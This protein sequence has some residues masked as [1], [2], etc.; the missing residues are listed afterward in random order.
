MEQGHGDDSRR[1]RRSGA[2]DGPSYALCVFNASNSLVFKSTAPAERHLRHEAM[3]EGARLKGFRYKDSA[4]TPDG[5]DKMRLKA[6]LQGKA[7]TQF[8]GKGD[9]LQSLNLPY[10][11][12]LKVQLQGANG[13]CWGATFSSANLT[14]NTSVQ[15]KGKGD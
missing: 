14:T 6:G 10:S 7:K 1:V 13:G 8:K 3:L 4:R 15:F 2:T 11:L 9:N 12:P 5:A